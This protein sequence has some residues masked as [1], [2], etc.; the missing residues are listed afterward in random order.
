MIAELRPGGEFPDCKLTDHAGA[1]RLLSEVTEE[2]ASVLHCY[3][4]WWCPKEQEFMRRLVDFQDE[5]E[6]AY[7]RIVSLTVDPPEIAAA[8]RAGIGARWTFL[9][10]PDRR[11][12]AELDLE[13]PTDPVHRP[14]LPYSFVLQPD[15]SIAAVFNGYWYWGRPT[16]EELRRSLRE[17]FRRTRPDWDAQ[18]DA[19]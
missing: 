2:H 19:A 12:Q 3:R 15:R 16:M 1:V 17:I 13:E 6:V 14:Y 8:F 11:V 9:S 18:A 7:S 4:G 10:D 5:A